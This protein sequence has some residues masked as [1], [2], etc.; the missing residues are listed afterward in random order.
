VEV[1]PTVALVSLEGAVR[2]QFMDPPKHIIH[3]ECQEC[4]KLTQYI[5]QTHQTVRVPEDGLC[6]LCW[7]KTTNWRKVGL[8]GQR[9]RARSVDQASRSWRTVEL[10]SAVVTATKPFMEEKSPKSDHTLLE[11]IGTTPDSAIV[12]R[13]PN[14]QVGSTDQYF[15]T[16]PKAV[17]IQLLQAVGGSITVYDKEIIDYDKNAVIETLQIYNLS[18]IRIQLTDKEYD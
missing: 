8:L 18:S 3:M 1:A 5:V 9:N 13:M 12:F 10:E 14:G 6:Q 17:L 2:S 15:T 11:P 7:Q 4:L 16:I